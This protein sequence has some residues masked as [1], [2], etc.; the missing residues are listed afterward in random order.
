MVFHEIAGLAIRA[1]ALPFPDANV[2]A[3]NQSLG[4]RPCL[5]QATFNEQL[6]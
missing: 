4:A 2:A 1:S 6:V 3:Q 5:R